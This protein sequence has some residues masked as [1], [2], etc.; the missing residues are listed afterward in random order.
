[1]NG[2]VGI[3]CNALRRITDP[4]DPEHQVQF[5]PGSAAFRNRCDLR[6]WA[7][8]S[9]M[10]LLQDDAVEALRSR[11]LRLPSKSSKHSHAS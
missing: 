5:R 3:D 11:L 7:N 6:D 8:S 4:A 9:R 10:D 1:M 2:R